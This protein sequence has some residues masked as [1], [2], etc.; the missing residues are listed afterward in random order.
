MDIPRLQIQ[1][2]APASRTSLPL[3]L[4]TP[5]TPAHNPA[6][7][8]PAALLSPLGDARAV[9][10]FGHFAAAWEARLGSFLN[11]EPLSRA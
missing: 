2:V 7:P 4:Q 6:V 1:H 5:V 8:Q 11:D 3:G 10:L 9:Q